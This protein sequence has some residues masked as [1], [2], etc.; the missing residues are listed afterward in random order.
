MM[1]IEFKKNEDLLR[2]LQEEFN[3]MY[4]TNYPG[5]MQWSYFQL[6][7]NCDNRELPPD[8]WREFV[9]D[10]RVQN[11]YDTELHL[12]LRSKSQELSH[13]AGTDR[14]TGTVTALSSVFNQLEKNK[15]SST[16]KQI[17]VYSFIPLT[18]S[19]KEMANVRVLDFIP[20]G[21]ENAIQRIG[22]KQEE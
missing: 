17:F 4:Q 7:K 20:E 2:E 19:E 15:E 16:D 10:R 8:A 3:I 11:W 22:N 6:W 12:T 18:P 5:I 14:S 21:I 9:L 13:K 1:N